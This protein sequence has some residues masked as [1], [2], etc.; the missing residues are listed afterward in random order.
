M[1]YRTMLPF[2][3]TPSTFRSFALSPFRQARC[4]E[5]SVSSALKFVELVE[6]NPDY[7]LGPHTLPPAHPPF[8]LS[9]LRHVQDTAGSGHRKLRSSGPLYRLTAALCFAGLAC[10]L[11]WPVA[12][13]QAVPADAPDAVTKHLLSTMQGCGAK[14]GA[15]TAGPECSGNAIESHIAMAR[16]ARWLMGP[17]W[18]GLGSE[19]Q[20]DF[21]QLLARLLRALVY[22]RASEFLATTRF[23]YGATQT[24]GNEA[25]VEV[26]VVNAEEERVALSFRLN[27]ADG[28]WQV[29]DVWLD[30]VSLANNIRKQ[31][32]SVVAKH[33]YDELVKRMRQKIDDA[34]MD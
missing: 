6:T 5:N 19:K 9:I 21:E 24:Q 30:G 16:L 7:P 22:Q 25:L 17:F 27:R 15:P 13:E 26:A 3:V 4:T 28:N 18:D 12:A 14:L 2:S 29:W 10:L 31:V 32:Q 23:E 33:S 11:G 20:A 1:T 34:S 8:A